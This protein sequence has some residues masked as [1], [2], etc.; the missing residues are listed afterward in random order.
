MGMIYKAVCSDCGH[1]FSTSEGGGFHFD[2]LRC[3]QCGEPRAVTH[4]ESENLRHEKVPQDQES[5]LVA[6]AGLTGACH[7]GGRFRYDAPVRCPEC[8]STAVKNLGVSTLY[9]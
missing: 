5:F 6:L 9:D 4:A 7:C 8:R 2:L 3:D 1:H